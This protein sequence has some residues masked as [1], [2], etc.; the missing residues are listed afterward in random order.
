MP[1]PTIATSALRIIRLLRGRRSAP[2]FRPLCISAA[3]TATLI[4]AS[5]EPLLTLRGIARPRVADEAFVSRLPLLV[6]RAGLGRS[7][8]G[9]I[10]ERGRDGGE[11]RGDHQ[12]GNE[13][14]HAG[15]HFRGERLLASEISLPRIGA[16]ARE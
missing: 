10:R 15:E 3:A 4:A 2:D 8:R 12:C 6:E 11:S 7:A 5:G 16:Q 1:A 14:A 13:R 9:R